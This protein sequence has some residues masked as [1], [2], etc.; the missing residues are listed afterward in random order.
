MYLIWGTGNHFEYLTYA[1][2]S[3]GNI[4]SW[5]GKWTRVYLNVLVGRARILVC[6][7]RKRV[8]TLVV[9]ALIDLNGVSSL[10]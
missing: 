9:Y 10:T 1:Y 4:H 3:D 6:V 8:N 5:Y 2:K 7:Y